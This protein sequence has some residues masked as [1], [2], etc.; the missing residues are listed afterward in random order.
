MITRTII[1][2]IIVLAILPRTRPILFRTLSNIARASAAALL[3]IWATGL[4]SGRRP[5]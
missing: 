3:V 4:G 2:A 5:W 1:L